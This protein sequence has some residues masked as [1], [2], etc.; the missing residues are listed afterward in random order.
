MSI[1]RPNLEEPQWSP[2]WLQPRPRMAGREPRRPSYVRVA[3]VGVV[4][5]ALL[6]PLFVITARVRPKL[7]PEGSRIFFGEGFQLQ[8][9]EEWRVLEAV[10]F[11]PATAPGLSLQAVGIDEI[12]SVVV[13]RYPVNFSVADDE[14]DE[15]HGLIRSRLFGVLAGSGSW[16]VQSEQTGTAMAGHPSYR[17]MVTSSGP[18]GLQ[19]ASRVT[20]VVE[21][22]TMFVVSCQHTLDRAVEIETG[23]DQ[24]VETFEIPG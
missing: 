16:T 9:P 4:G 12:N 7:P 6:I 2:D 23:C 24:V 1:E 21:G 15:I 5:L 14:L 10:R 20:V 8:Y 17:W 18:N 19:V 13:S 22:S 3:L 11:G